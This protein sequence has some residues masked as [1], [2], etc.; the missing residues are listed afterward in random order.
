MEAMR[1]ADIVVLDWLLKNGDSQYTLELLGNLISGKNDRNSLR[2]LAIYA[3]EA[4]LEKICG[5]VCKELTKAGL[6]LEKD[7]TGTSISY[8]HG[9]VVLYAKSGHRQEAVS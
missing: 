2:L 3:G 7:E 1:K 9:R 6:N 4:Q 8:Q 5:A